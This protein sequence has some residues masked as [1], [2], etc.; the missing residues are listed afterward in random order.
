MF[1]SLFSGIVELFAS[2]VAYCFPSKEML[3]AEAV[4][5]EWDVSDIAA[6]D[7]DSARP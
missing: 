4:D 6:P 3:D 5:R 7:D 2:F 1:N